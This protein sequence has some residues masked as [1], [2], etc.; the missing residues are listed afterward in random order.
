M[1]TQAQIVLE[2]TVSF[3]LYPTAILGTAIKNAKV[4]SIVNAQTAMD[5]GHDAP[6]LHAM[7]YPSLPPGTPNSYDKYLYVYLKLTSGAKIFIGIPWIKES[8]YA[9]EMI[10]TVAFYIE[11][12][13]PGQQ[14]Q[15]I[16]ALSAIGLTV[17]KTEIVNSADGN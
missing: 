12:I 17:A 16:Q 3:D 1:L 7:V 14:T 6:A 2:S 4:L 10:R 11:N 8:T 5:L 13:N 9:E 15:A